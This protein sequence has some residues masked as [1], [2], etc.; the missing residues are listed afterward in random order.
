MSVRIAVC[1]VVPPPRE[2]DSGTS[3]CEA[4]RTPGQGAGQTGG[5]PCWAR[6]WWLRGGTSD[7]TESGTGMSRGPGGKLD[8]WDK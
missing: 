6:E 2:R 1:P 8:E 4:G 5:T 7:G 3:S